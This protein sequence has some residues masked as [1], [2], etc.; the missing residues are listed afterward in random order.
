VIDFGGTDRITR[1]VT[2]VINNGALGAN[3][4]RTRVYVWS[5]NSSAVSNLL[6]SSET[7]ADG[8][9]TWQ[10]TYRDA[11]T[12]LTNRTDTAY[13][14]SGLRYQTNTA[15]DGSYSV[16]QYQYGRLAAVVRND[17]LGV[18]VSGMSYGYDSHGRQSQTIDARNG[19]TTYGY[20]NGD[21]VTSV[22]SP[23][24]GNGQNAQTTFTYY[25][26][27]LQV[28]GVTAP[29]GAST[30]YEY[31]PSGELKRSYGGRTYPVGYSYDLTFWR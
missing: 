31:Y 27:R 25:T 1:S 15:P 26:S 19:A 16:S 24:P 22:T 23:P 14:G 2:D 9:H 5:V 21:L 4:R 17:S 6:S 30:T 28:G 10:T 18:Q 11:A 29:D 7:S 12:P 8:L 20:N 3:V 13:A